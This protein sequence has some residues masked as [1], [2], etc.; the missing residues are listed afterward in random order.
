MAALLVAALVAGWAMWPHD[1]ALPVGPVA[2]TVGSAATPR[3]D[4]A[5]DAVGAAV[6]ADPLQRIAAAQPGPATA[7]VQA[8]LVLQVRDHRGARAG[9]PMLATVH[10]AVRDFDVEML[11]SLPP[12]AIAAAPVLDGTVVLDVPVGESLWLEVH[13]PDNL[14]PLRRRLEPPLVAGERRRIDIDLGPPYPW[15]AGRLLD[16]TGRPLRNCDIGVATEF[17]PT[18]YQRA[19]TDGD[20]RFRVRVLAQHASPRD[21]AVVIGVGGLR[22]GDLSG[23]RQDLWATPRARKAVALPIVGDAVDLG[24]FVLVEVPVFAAGRVVDGA[25]RP[26]GGVEVGFATMAVFDSGW[27]TLACVRAATAADGTFCARDWVADPRAGFRAV[28]ASPTWVGSAPR[29]F[30]AGATELELTVRPC[31]A[32]AGSVRLPA[33]GSQ[34]FYSLRVVGQPSADVAL[35]WRDVGTTRLVQFV[36]K[37]LAP[38]P[39]ELEVRYRDVLLWRC[40][41][42][43]AVLGV[44]REDERL[45]RVDVSAAVID[46]R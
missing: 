24:D 5:G 36:V 35:D 44:C 26:V 17:W 14:L 4:V 43:P 29:E 39:V 32:L 37:D 13:H 42:V 11:G 45:Q 3:I 20:G 25:G 46:E 41:G 1:A 33:A 21:G 9:S 15:F 7:A 16:A 28:V 12:P 34:L 23:H 22:D 6:A 19:R 30:A 31:A 2:A 38:G 8:S 10:A 40:S 18:E 27:R